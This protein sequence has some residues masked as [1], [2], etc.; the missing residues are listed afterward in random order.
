MWIEVEKRELQAIN[1]VLAF[2]AWTSQA[3]Y[4]YEVVLS[5]Q[6]LANQTYYF[7]LTYL[8]WSTICNQ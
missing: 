5:V 7:G 4:H 6:N 2:F 1:L 8:Y 3:R